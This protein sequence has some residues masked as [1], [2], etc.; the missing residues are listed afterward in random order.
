MRIVLQNNIYH[1][2]VELSITIDQFSDD[3]HWD[4]SLGIELRNG[5][6]L[7]KLST[8]QIGPDQLTSFAKELTKLANVWEKA[9]KQYY[10]RVNEP[11]T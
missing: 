6:M 7:T 8:E 9:I 5:D 4:H 1:P 2:T 11:I 10:E 3:T